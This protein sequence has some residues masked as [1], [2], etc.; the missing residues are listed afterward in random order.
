[1]EVGGPCRQGKGP[2]ICKSGWVRKVWKWVVH[3][4]KVRIQVFVRVG[5]S[6][7]CGRVVHIDSVMYLEK[8]G[9]CVVRNKN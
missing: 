2:G 8:W 6:V 3:A 7:W 4:D 5:G 9:F 1:M